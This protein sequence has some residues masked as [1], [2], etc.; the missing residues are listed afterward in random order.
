[1]ECSA[2]TETRNRCASVANEENSCKRPRVIATDTDVQNIVPGAESRPQCSVEAML[3]V[4]L[5]VIFRESPPTSLLSMTQHQ[6]QHNQRHKP[7]L[8]RVEAHT[9]I[10]TS[11]LAFEI[12]VLVE[13]TSDAL[14]DK[15]WCRSMS[16]KL[17]RKNNAFLKPL[18]PLLAIH[19]DMVP[20][21]A[22]RTFRRQLDVVM[23]ELEKCVSALRQYSEQNWTVA[24]SLMDALGYQLDDA[25]DGSVAAVSPLATEK[26]MIGDIEEEVCR[27]IESLLGVAAATT[28]S[29]DKCNH[30]DA[31]VLDLDI[32]M[33]DFCN[34][35]FGLKN[36]ASIAL[37]RDAC[38]AESLGMERKLSKHQ[39]VVDSPNSP[40]SQASP[41]S[42]KK[43]TFEI[44]A[45]SPDEDEPTEQESFEPSQER[46]PVTN[47]NDKKMLQAHHRTQLGQSMDQESSTQNAAVALAVMS[48]IGRG[49]PFRQ[50]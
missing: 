46:T 5:E 17:E 1:M 23:V 10:R 31:L 12:D 6:Q 35:L 16:Q 47:V 48:S 21:A 40:P 4:P 7:L 28:K 9:L 20:N 39:S 33:K 24:E 22:L 2:S 25:D 45:N 30:R 41:P 50:H 38:V 44:V 15:I 14:S 3:S 32:S 19:G 27:R 34:R 13:L 29:G 26:R 42:N 18:L 49:K 11:Q 8:T 43:D 37:L 36:Q